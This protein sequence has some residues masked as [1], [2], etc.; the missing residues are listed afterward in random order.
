MTTLRVAAVVGAG[1]LTL[2]ACNGG[3]KAADDPGMT[4]AMNATP[5][6]SSAPVVVKDGP[7][8]VTITGFAFAPAALSVPV[9]TK[10]TWTNQDEEPH[11]VIGS[12]LHSAVLGNAGSSYSYTFTRTGTYDYNCSIHPFMHG[13][14]TVTG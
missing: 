2:S 7:A 14:V 12:G 6:A 9:G 10:V 3:A 4:M 5:T 13:T 11:T 8:A 1:V